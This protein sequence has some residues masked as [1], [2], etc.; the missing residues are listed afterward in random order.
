MFIS[1]A[2]FLLH[3]QYLLFKVHCQSFAGMINQ[4]SERS[5]ASVAAGAAV[6]AAVSIFVHP[7]KDAATPAAHIT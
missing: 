1:H 3:K 5:S 6:V 2:I 4:N 7:A